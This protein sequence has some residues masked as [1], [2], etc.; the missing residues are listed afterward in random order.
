MIHLLNNHLIESTLMFELTVNPRF[1]ETDALGHVSNTT[2]PVWLEEARTPIFKLFVPNLAPT[3]WN[4]ILARIEMDFVAQMFYG[5]PIIIKTS[6]EKL[7]NTSCTLLQQAW[8]KDVLVIT[9]RSILVHFDY[10]TNKSKPIP[11]EIRQEL[12]KHLTNDTSD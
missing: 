6:V 12:E 8:Q 7:G 9:S 10:E 11:P 3:Q 5:Y 1:S 2:V 4:L